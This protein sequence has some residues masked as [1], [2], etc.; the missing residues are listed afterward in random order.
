M[1]R[2]SAIT[3]IGVETD[4]QL[5]GGFGERRERIPGLFARFTT[6]AEAN[7]AFA[8]PLPDR[9]FGRIVV[10]RQFRMLKDQQQRRFFGLGAQYA[11]AIASPHTPGGHQ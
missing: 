4:P 1:C 2:K 6:R 7:I 5:F 10:Q 8:H 3:Q 9:Q 11:Y